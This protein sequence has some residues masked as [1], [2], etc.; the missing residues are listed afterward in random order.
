MPF[1][2]HMLDNN[3]VTEVENDQNNWINRYQIHGLDGLQE[4]QIKA[5]VC[6]HASAITYHP[7]CIW[8]HWGEGEKK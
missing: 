2:K 6:R 3:S 5:G 1:F 4:K 7:L 8:C